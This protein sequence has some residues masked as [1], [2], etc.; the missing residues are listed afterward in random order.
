MMTTPRGLLLAACSLLLTACASRGPTL[1]PT[2]V[3]QDPAALAAAQAA[4]ATREAWL[5]GHASWGFEARVA[6]SQAGKGGSGR[7]DWQQQAGRYTAQLSAPVT[8]QSWRLSADGDGAL[9]EGLAG[10]PRQ[11]G[12]ADLLLREATGWDIPVQTLSDWARGIAA[13]GRAEFATNG[14]L[15]TLE[16]AGWQI[17]YGEWQAGQGDTPTMPRRIEAQRGESKVRLIVDHWQFDGP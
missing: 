8:R 14:Q 16:Q 4:Q 3:L 11:G 2:A 12:D 9:L 7:L 1:P 5:Q 6:V 13:A 17:R 15:Q 10:G